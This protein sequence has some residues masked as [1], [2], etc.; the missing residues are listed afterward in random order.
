MRAMV[1]EVVPEIE[2]FIFEICSRPEQRVIQILT[3]NSADQPFD[4]RMRQRNAGDTLD[5]GHL[6]NPQIGL[7][8]VELIKRIVVGA[9]VLR[10]PALPSNGAVEHSTK[11]DTIDRAGVDAEANDP[12][13]VLIHKDQDSVGPQR[14]RLA[15]EQI[16]TPEAVFHVTQE[17][18]P[19]GT[20]GVLSRPVVMGENPSNNVFVDWNVE[21]QGDLLGDSR[22]APA[23]IT[24]LHVDDRID[25]FCT[26]SFRAGLP[27]AI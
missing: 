11:C 21:R 1:V 14:R 17:S 9:E 23:G 20:P 2:Q 6:Q 26:R 15:P 4:E 13:R 5:S 7:P 24:L 27:T 19:G 22:T 8:L 10:H 18:Q 12:S 16:H 3:S 25:E